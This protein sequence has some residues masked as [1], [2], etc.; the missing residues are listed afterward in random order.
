MVATVASFSSILKEFYL[1]PVQEQLNNEVLVL[2]IMTKMSV[3]WNG[4]LAHIPVHIA[5]NT[6]VRYVG[7]SA[8]IPTAG[9]QTY[10]N[11]TVN[12]AFLYGRFEVTGPAIASA[13][14][15]GKNTFIGWMDAEMDKLVTDVKNESD[16]ACF[17]GGRMVGFLN[18]K[19][20]RAAG[21]PWQ[22]T[23]DIA[24][25][26]ALL[27][28]QAAP[29]TTTLEVVFVRC[30][31]GNA[32][33]WGFL[34]D[35]AAGAIDPANPSLITA[36]DPNGGTITIGA[37]GL[38]TNAVDDGFGVAVYIVDNSVTVP[39]GSPAGTPSVQDILGDIANGLVTQP[40][41][42]YGNLASTMEG[43]AA[44]QQR[45]HFGVDVVAND[46]MQ[47]TILTMSTAAGGARLGL[48]LPRLQQTFDE[49]LVRA[50]EEPDCLIMHPTMRQQYTALLTATL[51][52]FTNKAEKGD[53]GFTG[54]SYGGVPIKTAR[55]A[56]R[57]GV[58]FLNTKSW[59]ML[60][61]QPGGFADLDGNV[62]SRVANTD[63]W[64]GFY[65]WY[66]NSVC[67]RPNANALLV[68]IDL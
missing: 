55:H 27:A 58:L 34:V 44:G 9:Q 15:G 46:V 47:S 22:F 2:D 3:D 61:L 65:R 7:E 45:N 56:P 42:I 16:Q 59:K 23:G 54:L 64:E 49:V 52:T 38:N 33:A 67:M 10:A 29:G 63:S 60:E 40:V 35:A 48:A 51:Q 21:N 17:S 28:T 12:A 18:E 68:G 32:A 19:D 14:Q 43:L 66:Y 36:A 1:G 20:S 41:G 50:D 25:I 24:K 39:A 11:Y 26:Q 37:A 13:G 4:R 5:R 30:D 6:G 62:L 8:A 53:G 31:F 57:G